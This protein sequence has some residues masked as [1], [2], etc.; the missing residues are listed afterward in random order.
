MKVHDNP[1]EKCGGE[2]TAIDWPR[3]ALSSALPLW[4]VNDWSNSSGLVHIAG[5]LSLFLSTWVGVY[6]LLDIYIKSMPGSKF[7]L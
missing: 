3:E 1:W 6:N 5:L 4:H 2:W 7:F